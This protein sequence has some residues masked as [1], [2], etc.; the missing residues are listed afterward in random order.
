[1]ILTPKQM[2]DAEKYAEKHGTSLWELMQNAGYELYKQVRRS[3][4]SLM[5]NNIL[6]L[7]GK[8]NNG[9]DGF[10]CANLLAK[11]GMNV[12]VALL[13]Q[14]PSSELAKRAFSTLSGDVKI[15][16]DDIADGISKAD[17]IVDAVFGTGFKGELPETVRRTFE[18]IEKSTALKIA[19]DIPSG[20]NA[21]TGKVAD[22]TIHFEKTVTFHA[23]KLGSMLKPANEFCGEISIC[24]IGIPKEIS[25]IFDYE[26][27]TIN[28]DFL[29]TVLK[30]RPSDCHKG[31]F[32]KALLVC[33]SDEYK[34]AAALS[35][36]AALRSGVGLVELF[37]EKSVCDCLFT[38]C[39]EA[40]YTQIDKNNPK[41]SA[42]I[43]LEKSKNAD[44]LLIG[45]GI[46]NN[47]NSRR[48]IEEI[49]TCCE[50][51]VIIDAD[52]INSIVP[53]INVLLNARAEIILTPH[54]AELARICGVTVEEITKNRLDFAIQTAKKY[55]CIVVSKDSSTFITDGKTVLLSQSGNS[56]LSKG[57]SG[58]ILAGLTCSVIAQGTPLI[59]GCACASF[60]L[61]RTAEFLCK[62]CSERGIIGTDVI[63]ALPYVFKNLGI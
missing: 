21:L 1:M 41:A 58:D 38:A 59:E 62:E 29:K 61:G 9:G 43:I 33:G 39:P 30:K 17:I 37:S 6:I 13:C 45:C 16:C 15:M 3:A 56:A 49:I 8:G 27:K 31:T 4:Y 55:G 20:V 10:V 18:L 2:A 46:S 50:I 7:C 44:A 53:N 48:L 25:E 52:G 34:G 63:S 54:P 19:C 57:G 11:D 28:D 22:G 14:E 47:K 36:A 5:K 12:A 60:I 35:T 32:G 23:E 26:I 40:I 51:P 42:E 24:D